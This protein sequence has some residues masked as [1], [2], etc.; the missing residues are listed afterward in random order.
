MWLLGSHCV[1]TFLVQPRCL[2]LFYE[3]AVLF[4][5]IWNVGFRQHY[6]CRDVLS[7]C[8]MGL[9]VPL[10]VDMMI[11]TPRTLCP[12]N[13]GEA[14]AVVTDDSGEGYRDSDT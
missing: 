2:A 8:Y 6:G 12:C 3:D 1:H 14:L 11:R 13:D 7:G 5:S 9:P 10:P 4:G